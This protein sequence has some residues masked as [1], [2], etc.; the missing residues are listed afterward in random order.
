MTSPLWRGPLVRAIC[1]TWRRRAACGVMSCAPP[2][3]SAPR[4]GSRMCGVPA[5]SDRTDVSARALSERAAR[6]RGAGREA[7]EAASSA[8]AVIAQSTFSLIAATTAHCTT[9]L[10]LPRPALC[11]RA[12]A[13]CARRALSGAC[14]LL[15]VCAPVPRWCRPAGRTPH[16]GARRRGEV[17]LLAVPRTR[18]PRPDPP[19]AHPDVGTSPPLVPF[20]FPDPPCP[21]HQRTHPAGF[22]RHLHGSNL[23]R[24]GC[25]LA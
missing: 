20:R 15:R 18:P 23:G 11:P 16:V 2:T 25:R 4:R 12:A 8:T 9:T 14:S 21:P 10:S 24:V 5:Q 13:G 1:M 17:Q 19:L 22:P 3:T 7:H 6:E